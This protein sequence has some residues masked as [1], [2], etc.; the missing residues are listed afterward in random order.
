MLYPDRQLLAHKS[1][2]QL[3]LRVD[4]H[5]TDYGAFLVYRSLVA[6]L[7]GRS[8]PACWRKDDLYYMERTFT[9]DLGSKLDPPRRRWRD[10]PASRTTC[11][12]RCTTTAWREPVR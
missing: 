12:I 3:F 1:E 8:R 10:S 11:R 5:W 6:A 7:P 2:H 4:T 9:G